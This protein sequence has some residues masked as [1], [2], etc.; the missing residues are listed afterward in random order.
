MRKFHRWLATL[1]MLFFLYMGVTGTLVQITEINTGP[2]LIGPDG[3]NDVVTAG[4][5]PS[6][7]NMTA[8]PAGLAGAQPVTVSSEPDSAAPAGM[9]A[10]PANMAGPPPMPMEGLVYWRQTFKNFHGGGIG[11]VPGQWVVFGF[12]ISIFVMTIT[13]L[14]MYFQL[15]GQRKK[16]GKEEWFWH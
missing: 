2:T 15:L 7:Q 11:G 9:G 13:G 10:P 5:M 8:P 6:A 4:N 12:G 3:E 14:I 1:G 16:T